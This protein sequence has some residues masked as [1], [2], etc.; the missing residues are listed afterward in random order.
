MIVPL[1][2]VL[3]LARFSLAF[4]LTISSPSTKSAWALKERVW[5]FWSS[6]GGPP[7]NFD[8]IDIDLLFGPGEGVFIKNISYGVPWNEQGAEWFV[9]DNLPT[10]DD[11]F[12]RI[13]GHQDPDFR[14]IGPKF[15]I[16][17][18]KGFGKQSSGSGPRASTSPYSAIA[19]AMAIAQLI[20][21]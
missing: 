1:L 8:K 13:T 5:V 7:E 20:F 3:V 2:H 18:R 15:S 12:I 11:Y 6:E 10:R 19:F 21:L 4:K 14:V 17:G 16:N 9:A